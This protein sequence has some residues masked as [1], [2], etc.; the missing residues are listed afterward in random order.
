MLI[1]L[2]RRNIR[3]RRSI[4]GRRP[5][6]MTGV[7]MPQTGPGSEMDDHLTRLLEAEAR[8]QGIIDASKAERQRIIDDALAAVRNGEE[9]FEAGRADLRS[10]FLRE[11]HGRAEH[12]VA[13]LTLK[14]GER[15]RNLREMAFRHEQE[16]IN[17][18]LNLIADPD[19]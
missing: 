6:R 12:A 4:T 10:P 13:E 3:A 2:L 14:F 19:R 16:A 7:R 18:A 5:S 17:A 8:A 15:Q 11:A 9:R 1:D